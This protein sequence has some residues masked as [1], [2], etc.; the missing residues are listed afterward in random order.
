MISIIIPIYNVEKYLYDCLKSVSSQSYEDFE[1][2]LIDDGSTDKSG[3]ICD[4]YVQKDNRFKVYH[5]QNG[6]V[7]SARNFALNRVSGEWIYFCDADDILYKDT[8]KLLL[9]DIDENTICSM[10]GYVKVNEN[11]ETIEENCVYEKTKMTI[12][13]T[14]IDFYSPKYSMFNGYIWN[15]LFR[16]D[17]IQKNNLR[18]RED[19]YIKEDGFFLVQY[20]C[21]CSGI[22]AYNTQ[23]I[24]K[25]VIHPSS[26]M[27]SKFRTINNISLSRL[28][29]TL[30]CHKEIK[31]A[32]YIC[33]LP[34]AEKYVF[35]V[36]RFLLEINQSKGF[37][38]L[39]N[40]ITI[41]LMIARVLTIFPLL[42]LYAN[43]IKECL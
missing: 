5:K 28:V 11:L 16:N 3:K 23:P 13:E 6:G 36:R 7:S 18:F 35:T 40:R 37:L 1:A 41:D 31:R 29:A 39:K 19:I 12:E 14:L 26:A 15:R 10:G 32:N 30:E 24:Y 42:K 8:L 9:E 25:Y 21:H 17:I 2:F 20:L 33:A 34:Y 27:R 43:K 22:V 4:E 38:Y